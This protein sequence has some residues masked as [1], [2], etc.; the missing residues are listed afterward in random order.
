MEANGSRLPQIWTQGLW[1]RCFN[2]RCS[3]CSCEM[4]RLRRKWLS[5]SCRGGTPAS[6]STAVPGF[7]PKTMRPWPPARRVYGSERKS[8]PIYRPCL[9]LPGEDD[10]IPCILEPDKN[11]KQYRKNWVRLIQKIGACPG[12]DPGRLTPFAV[13]NARVGCVSWPSSR[14][15]RSSRRSSWRTSPQTP[16]SMGGQAEAPTQGAEISVLTERALYRLFPPG[17]RPL[18]AGSRLPCATFGYWLLCRSGIPSG[19]PHLSQ[20]SRCGPDGESCPFSPQFA[21]SQQF[22]G[23]LP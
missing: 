21:P 20:K 8:R 4:A 14:M 6:M 9:L 7:D 1:K 19:P 23:L 22:S 15:K 2:T 13:P 16:R 12:P 3:R 5:L 18:W 11:S 10:L 17:C